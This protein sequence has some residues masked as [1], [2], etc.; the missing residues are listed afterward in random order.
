MTS[1][2]A[3]WVVIFTSLRAVSAGAATGWKVTVRIAFEASGT[4]LCQ[5]S[6][7]MYPGKRLSLQTPLSVSNETVQASSSAPPASPIGPLTLRRTLRYPGYFTA[8]PVWSRGAR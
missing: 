7:M 1:A 5:G 6:L 2:G 8:L 3:G 4:P